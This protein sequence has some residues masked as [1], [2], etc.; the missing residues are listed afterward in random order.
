MSPLRLCLHLRKHLLP[1]VLAIFAVVATAASVPA[2]VST[3]KARQIAGVVKQVGGATH[4]T[5]AKTDDIVLL[6]ESFTLPGPCAGQRLP[7]APP[8]AGVTVSPRS[9]PQCRAPPFHLS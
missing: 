4:S 3:A 9:T 2:E 1:A 6:A 7:A 5:F 8:P